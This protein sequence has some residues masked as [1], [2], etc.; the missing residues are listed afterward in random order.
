MDLPVLV[1]QARDGDQVIRFRA[2]VLAAATTARPG[3]VRW[4][5]ETVYRIPKASE[6]PPAGGYVVAK[7]GRS[8]VAHRPTCRLANPRRMSTWARSQDEPPEERMPCME[9]RPNLDP[10]IT[11]VLLERTRYQ[12]LQ[13]RDPASLAAILLPKGP[14]MTWMTG[15]TKQLSEQVRRADAEFDSWWADKVEPLLPKE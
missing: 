8:Q 3:S 15:M 6:E 14:A 7:V 12:L 1:R 10:P 4:T 5:E 2:A 13:A 11:G 9:C